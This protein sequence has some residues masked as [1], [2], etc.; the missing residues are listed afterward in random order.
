MLAKSPV[1]IITPVFKLE[2]FKKTPTPIQVRLKTSSY[3]FPVLLANL[4]ERGNLNVKV[5]KAFTKIFGN[6]WP[7]ADSEEQIVLELEEYVF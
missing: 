7:G 4:S 5:T 3:N 6:E 2:L 1:T